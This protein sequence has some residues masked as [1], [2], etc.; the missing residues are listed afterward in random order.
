L[1]LRSFDGGL[2]LR[3]PG[4]DKGSAVREVLAEEGVEAA[5]A[6]LGDDLTDEDAFRALQGKGLAALVRPESRPTAAD[7][8][9]QAPDELILFLDRWLAAA[10]KP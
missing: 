5:A 1:T 10:G 8:W 6:Y 9:L 3:V 2:E 7:I 4:R